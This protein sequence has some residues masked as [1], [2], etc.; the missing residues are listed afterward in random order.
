[1]VDTEKLRQLVYK[2]KFQCHSIHGDQSIPCTVKEMNDLVDNI[3][4]LLNS[5]IDELEKD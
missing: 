1:M 2:F 4:K 5:F 3:A